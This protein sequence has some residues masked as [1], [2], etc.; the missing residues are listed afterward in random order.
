M[1]GLANPRPGA[2]ADLRLPVPRAAARQ[3]DASGHARLRVARA[4]RPAIT[5]ASWWPAPMTRATG[6]D[7][8]STARALPITKICRNRAGRRRRPIAA[9]GLTPAPCCQTGGHRLSAQA[10][11]E[12]RADLAG[13]GRGDLG[14]AAGRGPAA[15]L[16]VVGQ[17]DPTPGLPFIT[18]P[19]RDRAALS[20]GAARRHCRA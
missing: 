12:G 8:S 17:T 3:G 10:V 9:L 5:A 16:K 4:A 2:V 14:A 7:G 1:G 19:G 13:A 20:A 18:A 11:A 6:S 15:A